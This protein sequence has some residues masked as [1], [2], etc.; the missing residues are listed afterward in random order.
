M[1]QTLKN[2]GQLHDQASPTETQNLAVIHSFLNQWD[3]DAD[4]VS[5]FCQGLEWY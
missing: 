1:N 4:L 2:R 3:V 5:E